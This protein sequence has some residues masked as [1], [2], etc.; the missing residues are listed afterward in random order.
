MPNA[1]PLLELDEPAAVHTD[2]ACGRSPFVL[3]CDH[4]GNAIPRRLGSLGLDQSTLRSHVAWDIGALGVARHL[5]ALLEAPLVWQAYSR[6]VIDCNRGPWAADFI[7]VISED[8]IIACNRSVSDED[9]RPRIEEIFEPYHRQLS[10]ILDMQSS[11]VQPA[12]VAVH[13]FTPV[14]KGVARPWQVG[15]LCNRDRR[16]AS[17]L[18]EDLRRQGDLCVGDN[19]PYSVSDETDFTIPVH[20]EVRGIPHVEIEIRQDLIAG[21]PGQEEWAGLLADCLRRALTRLETNDSGVTP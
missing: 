19:E 1:Y 3:A 14:F 7:P 9:R 15:I 2:G 11:S 6:L 17:L 12:L 21:E 5:A 18:L 16:L 20:G 8:T 4:A 10:A 13:S